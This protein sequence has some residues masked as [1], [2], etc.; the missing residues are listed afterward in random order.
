M[1][2]FGDFNSDPTADFFARERA[3]LGQDADF[4]SSNF[5]TVASPPP[6]FES[7]FPKAEH[8][9]SSQAFHK[10]MLPDAEPDVVRQWREKQAEV[11]AQRDRQEAERKAEVIN[12]AREDID[13]F[14]EEY[15]DRKQRAIEENRDREDKHVLKRQETPSNIW[16]GVVSEIN[17]TNS[18]AAFPT[19]D[20][21][22]MK[23]LLI[24]LRKDRNAPGTIIISGQ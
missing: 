5:E 17:I 21:S 8:L 23:S 4:F 19:R 3:V 14:Y 1:S 24:D 12:R 20:V 18:K 7:N 15:N 16:S 10:A 11:I 2:D 6:S 22:R 9:E 13:K